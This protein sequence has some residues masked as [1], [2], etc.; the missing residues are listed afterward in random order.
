MKVFLRKLIALVLL[1]VATLA[2]SDG[3]NFKLNQIPFSYR[4]S[5]LAITQLTPSSIKYVQKVS[6]GIYIR[7]ISRRQFYNY[8]IR[9]D[10]LEGDKIVT[11]E[12]ISSPGKLTLN[13]NAG[14]VEFCFENPFVIRMRGKNLGIKLSPIDKCYAVP[15]NKKQLRFL[16]GQYGDFFYM[17]TSLKGNF[18]T[19]P[20]DKAS[21]ESPAPN[22]SDDFY[23]DFFP[24]SSGNFEAALEEFLSEWVPRTYTKTFNSCV[25][26]NDAAFRQWLKRSPDVLPRYEAGRAVAQYQNWGAMVAPRGQL[27]MEAMLMSKNWMNTYYSWDNCFNAIALAPGQSK[28]AW[29]QF[30]GIFKHQSK[31]GS[32]PDC[33]DDEK[34]AWGIVKTPV[35]GWALQKMMEI[36]GMVTRKRM[37][38]IYPYLAAWTN[39]WFTY[40][41]PDGNGLP[42]YYH[43]FESFDDTPPFDVGLPI[44]G[45]ELATFL[46]IQMNTLEKLAVT[47]GKQTEAAQWKIRAENLL[48]KLMDNLWN[49]EQFISKNS[50]TGDYTKG[51]Q[52]FISYVP[53]L[54]GN[55]LP[56]DIRKKLIEKLKHEGELLTVFGFATESLTSPFFN[57]DSYT[58]GSIWAP[59]NYILIDGLEA[60]GEHDFAKEVA[61]RY[62]DHLAKTSFSERHDALT[63]KPLS[64]PAYTWTSSVF[65]ILAHNYLNIDNKSSASK[66]GK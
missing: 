37:E 18:S 24:D 35:H 51:S 27:K 4:G 9:V 50:N 14:F 32:L 11:P 26:D 36:P 60:C 47:L 46:I 52:S 19:K 3:V 64:D 25:L 55:K 39:F 45:P 59:I 48:K 20:L 10:V 15:I 54:L 65:L 5:Y 66:T 17:A 63:G 1:P 34:E 53:L 41:D 42:Q 28:E 8:M 12:I 16:D 21:T 38:E 61:K 29:E 62:C 56:A 30:T 57:T 6:D 58:R 44:E 49:G 40:R 31:L 22:R 33:V 7:N 43:S 23:L 13:T 2:Q